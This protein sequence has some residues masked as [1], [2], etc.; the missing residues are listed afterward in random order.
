MSTV[1]CCCLVS[2][3]RFR[4][5]SLPKGDTG[6]ETEKHSERYHGVSVYVCVCAHGY[7]RVDRLTSCPVV[8]GP[9]GS[10]FDTSAESRALPGTSAAGWQTAYPVSVGPP[11]ALPANSKGDE[12]MSVWWRHKRET[13][14]V[15]EGKRGRNVSSSFTPA[16][17]PEAVRHYWHFSCPDHPLDSPSVQVARCFL[18]DLQFHLEKRSLS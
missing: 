15:K 11:P 5:L 12:Q 16:R 1:T 3:L 8:P 6:S 10:L 14:K 4:Q 13:D 9:S 17:K 2:F 18:G 7:V